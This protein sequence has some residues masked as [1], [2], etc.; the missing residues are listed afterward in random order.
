MRLN[1]TGGKVRGRMQKVEG[2]EK[3]WVRG[4]S[5]HAQARGIGQLTEMHGQ[6]HGGRANRVTS[7]HQSVSSLPLFPSLPPLCDAV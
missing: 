5:R 1:A 4:R 3:N 7:R 6:G 2:N